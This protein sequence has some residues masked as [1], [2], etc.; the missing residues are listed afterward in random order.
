MIQYVVQPRASRKHGKRSRGN[1]RG[2]YKLPGMP[3]LI[4]V[5]L[6]T[7]DKRVAE[8]RLEQI[9]REK[10]QEA[11]GI[12]APR[13]LREGAGK[14][15]S[16]HVVDLVA[17][18]KAKGRARRYYA[19][20]KVRIERLLAQ[21]EWHLPR[22]V[23]ADGFLAWRSRQ[24]IAPKT[25]NEYLGAMMVL[26]N[27][28]QRHGR[29]LANPLRSVEKVNTSGREVVRRRAL[30]DDEVRRLL[31]AAGGRRTVYLMAVLTGLRRS[32]LRGL[33]WG[34]V[35]LE[36]ARPFLQAR[37]ATT[38]NRKDAV[39]FL[40]DDL[41]A[42]LRAMR[43]QGVS[44]G[45]RLVRVPK[46]ETVRADLEAAGIARIDAMGRKV[47]LHALRH[48]LAT[49]LARAGVAPRVAMDVMRH[50]DM[51]LTAKTYTDAGLL[52]IADA[53]DRL[54]R[55]QRGESLSVVMATGTDA[56]DASPMRPQLRPQ[57]RPQAGVAS[58]L[59]CA[60]PVALAIA[61]EIEISPDFEAE[62]RDLSQ[63]VASCRDVQESEGDGARTRNLRIDSPVL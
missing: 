1:W 35:H 27:W 31:D 40:R 48:T 57:M 26:L 3:K 47:D 58:C 62:R 34:D 23:T 20:V 14:P 37:S 42:E 24:S 30:T 52:P 9:V 56:P 6:G 25:L 17:D 21:C 8:Q 38:K 4:E 39:I 49:N 50:S 22:D 51:R 54:P 5:A 53:V 46:P 28:M 45:R 32:E 7:T 43:P 10:Q 18:L 36:A 29:L 44:P 12:I 16:E 59:Q 2:R 60:Q 33:V 61:P 13:A 63:V 15:L 11:A 55:Y 41:V 19:L